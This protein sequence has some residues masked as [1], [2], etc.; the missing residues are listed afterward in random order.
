MLE[1]F[2]R[3][4]L[5]FS[6]WIIITVLVITSVFHLG[7]IWRLLK[8]FSRNFYLVSTCVLS[9]FSFFRI[10]SH[11]FIPCFSRFSSGKTTTNQEGPK[12]I[13]PNVLFHFNL[14]FSQHFLMLLLFQSILSASKQLLPLRQNIAHP[15][16]HHFS[17]WH[18]P[19]FIRDNV[20]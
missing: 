3:I 17:W 14:P 15:P 7:C 20:A 19:L 1:R 5:F 12:F 4:A 13:K 6:N 10:F 16:N 11:C 8:I 18:L 9:Q 2:P